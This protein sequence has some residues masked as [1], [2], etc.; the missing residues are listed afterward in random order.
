[1]DIATY[2]SLRQFADSWGLVY[3]LAIFGAV[4]AMLFWRGARQR[5]AEAAFIPLVDDDKPLTGSEQ[6]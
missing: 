1:M 2:E 5:A 6:K 3:M 4:M